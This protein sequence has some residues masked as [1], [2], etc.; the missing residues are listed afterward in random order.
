MYSCIYI[1]IHTYVYMCVYVNVYASIPGAY[2]KTHPNI[3]SPLNKI[4]P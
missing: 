2:L 1:C 4:I 3:Y